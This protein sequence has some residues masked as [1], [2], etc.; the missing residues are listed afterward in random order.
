MRSGLVGN[1]CLHACRTPITFQRSWSAQDFRH[2][3]ARHSR[4]QTQWSR[5]N[6]PHWLACPIDT[7]HVDPCPIDRPRAPIDRGKPP[8]ASPV[9]PR[10]N[11]QACSPSL[12]SGAWP[13][14]PCPIDRGKPPNASPVVPGG[15]RQACSPP[16]LPLGHGQ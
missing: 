14:D 7:C 15:N 13:V 5:C 2:R 10:G 12:A 9:V 3:I 1:H 8:N 4:W 16:P 11:R 6:M